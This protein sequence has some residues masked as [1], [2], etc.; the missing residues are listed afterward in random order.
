MSSRAHVFTC[1]ALL[2]FASTMNAQPAGTSPPS[3][4]AKILTF[5]TEHKAGR[6]DFEGTAEVVCEPIDESFGPLRAAERQPPYETRKT[7]K[8]KGKKGN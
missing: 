1:I 4:L 6:F 3:D 5:E 2:L 7:R 8:T